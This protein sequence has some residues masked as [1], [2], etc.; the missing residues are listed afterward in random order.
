MAALGAR[1][2]VEPLNVAQPSKREVTYAVV[3]LVVGSDVALD[4]GLLLEAAFGFSEGGHRFFV[5][6]LDGT[7]SMRRAL[8]SAAG[9]ALPPVPPSSGV[10]SASLVTSNR[11]RAAGFWFV[12]QQGSFSAGR[13]PALGDS[14]CNASVADARAELDLFD[15]GALLASRARSAGAARLAASG[16]SAAGDGGPRAE[17]Y[18]ASALEPAVLMFMKGITNR[19]FQL[20]PAYY[21]RAS[22]APGGAAQR[23]LPGGLVFV[24]LSGGGGN[25]SASL[26][27][28]FIA[29]L[30][31]A[32]C[33]AALLAQLVW[34][35]SQQ[36]PAGWTGQAAC[37]PPPSADGGGAARAAGIPAW[38]LSLIVG[39]PLLGGLLALASLFLYNR[40]KSWHGHR[41]KGTNLGS[42]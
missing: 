39:G 33:D 40:K 30:V 32:T 17:L 28:G 34:A 12:S 15:L 29:S 42:L 13:L 27:E 24:P 10:W 16:G 26:G 21:S 2:S 41:Q 8:V 23:A 11:T 20:N 3:S 31:G 4:L 18:F 19:S 36:A 7:F 35:A 6:P 14:T 5:C 22:S 37:W 38:E 1:F 25:A 9:P